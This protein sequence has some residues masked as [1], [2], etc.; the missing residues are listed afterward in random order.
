MTG[1][2][3]DHMPGREEEEESGCYGK[4]SHGEWTLFGCGADWY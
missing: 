2:E 1:I 4:K 3:R